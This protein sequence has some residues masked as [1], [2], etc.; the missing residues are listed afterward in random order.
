MT[1]SSNPKWVYLLCILLAS[2]GM[3]G[4]M[5][6]QIVDFHDDDCINQKDLGRLLA[7]WYEA[8]PND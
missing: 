6:P 8:T 1:Q 4:A 5:C 2:W 7:M 3:C